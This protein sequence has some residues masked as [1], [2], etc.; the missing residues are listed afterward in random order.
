MTWWVDQQSPGKWGIAYIDGEYQ[1]YPRRLLP[2][3]LSR[4]GS[5]GW[6]L[7]VAHTIEERQ[8]VYVFKRPRV[9]G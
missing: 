7:T 3:A 8:A 9:E 1:E 2:E 4:A 6:E 5:D